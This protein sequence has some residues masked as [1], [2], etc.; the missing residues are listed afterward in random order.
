MAEQPSSYTL[1][2]PSGGVDISWEPNSLQV[3]YTPG[4]TE[5]QWEFP[6]LE[7]IYT[8]GSVKINIIEYA[9]IDIEYLGTP[10][11]IPKSADPNY[12]PPNE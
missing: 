7:L 12:V 6:E 2:L 3:Q 9:S 1:F 4:E 10:F 5:F 11:Y 8:P